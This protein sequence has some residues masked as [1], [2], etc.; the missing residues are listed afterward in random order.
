MVS[1]SA[2]VSTTAAIGEWRISPGAGRGCSAGVAM[3]CCR[4]S[5]EAF[6]STQPSPSAETASEAWLR[7][8]AAGSPA[9][10]RR[11]PGPA[12]FHCGKP[13]PA[14]APRTM[15]V[16]KAG[17]KSRGAQQARRGGGAGHG[18]L[19][20]RPL[21]AA[22]G[23]N[24]GLGRGRPSP[25]RNA[26]AW[27][28]CRAKPTN[29]APPPRQHPGQQ[30]PR[31]RCDPAAGPRHAI[32]LVRARPGTPGRPTES[33]DLGAGVAVDFE[34]KRDLGHARLVPG[35]VSLRCGDDRPIPIL[36][37]KPGSI[38]RMVLPSV[39][40]GRGGPTGRVERA[41]APGLVGR[42]P[43]ARG[44]GSPAFSAGDWSWATGS[45]SS[46]PPAMWGARC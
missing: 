35:H 40:G 22:S 46:A 1:T 43:A 39:R 24:V 5:G 6:S 12:E 34:S 30:K 20:R 42:S 13:P 18:V 38:K 28:R 26:E 10:A 16:G 17:G 8:G 45:R 36:G 27:G 44:F 19:L 33:A 7:A 29:G 21:R 11:Q 4:R 37:S 14:A 23:G 3:I 32:R 9:S 31:G 25:R 15:A 2:P 41:V